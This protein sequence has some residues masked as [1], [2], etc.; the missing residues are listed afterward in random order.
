MKWIFT[1]LSISVFFFSAQAQSLTGTVKSKNG[2]PLPGVNVLL[3]HLQDSALIKAAVTDTTGLFTFH[4]VAPRD[5]LVS[6]SMIGYAKT[7]MHVSQITTGLKLPN[8]ELEETASELDEVVVTEKRPFIEQ[9][10]DKMVVNVANSIIASGS[11]ALEVLEKTPGVLVNRSTNSLQLMGRSGVQVQMNGKPTYL[12]TADVVSLL[13]SLPS[14]NIDRIEVI[15]TP[16]AKEDASGSGGIINIIMLKNNA[17]GTN[18]TFTM[19]LGRARYPRARTS[20]LL[21]HRTKS[22]NVFANYGINYEENF[23]DYTTDQTIILNEQKNMA[24]QSTHTH[25][26]ETAQNAKAGLDYFLTPNTTVGVMWTGNWNN[27]KEEGIATSAFQKPD[28]T[29]FYLQTR[30]DKTTLNAVS[31]QVGN[32]NFQHNFPNKK[33]ALSADVDVA[34]FTRSFTNTLLTESPIESDPNKAVQYLLN[35]I[36]TTITINTA[37]IDFSHTV[38]TKW[39]LEAGAK[40]SYVYT[41]NTITLTTNRR[42]GFRQAHATVNQFQYTERIYA[43]YATLAGSWGEKTSVKVGLR[44]EHTHSL[45]NAITL[46][47]K[48][49]RDYLKFFPSVFLSHE[50]P[51]D[52]TL[53]FSY[54]YRIGRPS[55]QSLNPSRSYSDPYFYKQG[56]AFLRPEYTH[57][58]EVKHIFKDKLYASLNAVI[59]TDYMFLLMQPA[60]SIRTEQTTINIG[61]SRRYYGMVSLPVTISKVWNIQAYVYGYYNTFDFHYQGNPL[62]VIQLSGLF[63]AANSFSFGKGWTSELLCRL[64]SPSSNGYRKSPWLGNADVGLQKA[65]QKNIKLK[66]SIQD[67]FH[68]RYYTGKIDTPTYVATYKQ[69]YDSR[70]VMINVTY[71]FGNQKLKANRQRKVGSED[72][73]GR[74]NSG[75]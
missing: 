41:D 56:N 25:Y 33:G 28:A 31:N 40:T 36:P 5:Y 57:T 29:Y 70:L 12:S 74:M 58:F 10:A 48:V 68:S 4:D 59:D 69:V 1:S 13:A 35:E 66:L 42:D 32:I 47:N 20:L 9:F 19:G 26:F 51:N 8:I 39:K 60:D 72:E 75:G 14:D 37:K 18:G 27:D 11:T 53:T 49:E 46:G 15:S 44:A 45:G 7:T 71:T 50:L 43:G 62:Y 16:S 67:I 22:F 30:T 17:V 61:T 54:G 55:Y 3:L 6:L 2:E 21:N 23:L 38:L 34:Y 63:Y 64:Y 73:T 24:Y 65:F 52:Q